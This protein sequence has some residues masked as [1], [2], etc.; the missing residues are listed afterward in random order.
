[1]QAGETV[2]TIAEWKA[3]FQALDQ[4]PW[5][6]PRPLAP[7]DATRFVGRTKEARDFVNR[8]KQHRLVVLSGESGVGK[9]SLLNARLVPELA[10]VG[11]TPLVCREWPSKT[12]SQSIDD[13]VRAQA[14]T[15]DLATSSGSLLEQLDSTFHGRAVVI[16][17]QLEEVIRYQPQLFSDLSQWVIEANH[18][19]RTRFVLSLR[20][21]YSHS[22]RSIEKAA[23]PFSFS[24]QIL[25]H[26]IDSAQVAEVISSESAGT[27]GRISKDAADI[28]L[29]HWENAG[30][31]SAR[32]WHGVGLLHLQATLYALHH[33]AG[34]GA[35]LIEAR[36][37]VALAASSE[38]GTEHFGR[39]LTV[40]DLGL[41][42]AIRVKL[43]HCRMACQEPGETGALDATLVA[44][45]E[46]LAYR[47]VPHLYSGGYK[48]E[49][50]AGDLAALTLSRELERLTGEGR[51]PQEAF[52]EA[53]CALKRRF[54]VV[55]GR[56]R[57]ALSAGEHSDLLTVSRHD[58][59]RECASLDA[60]LPQASTDYRT[61]GV[62]VEPWVE[63]PLELS[64]GPMLGMPP[65]H[66]LIEEMRRLLFAQHWLETAQLVRSSQPEPDR[67]ML[68]LIHDGFADA[69]EWLVRSNRTSPSEAL[70]LLT[71]ARGRTFD[72]S[73][74]EA[75]STPKEFSG[76]GDGLTWLNLRWNDCQVTASFSQLVFA[77]CDF[78]GT[79]FRRCR[80]E[81][82][83]FVNCLMD[84]VSFEECVV[85]GDVLPASI[86]QSKDTRMGV[87]A[88][89]VQVRPSQVLEL[90][91]YR[92]S[93]GASAPL[94]CFVYSRTS[95]VSA[96]PWQSAR[97]WD[98]I[99]WKPG[100]GGVAMFG[101]RLSSL[102]VRACLFEDGGALGL[103]FVAGAAL[104]IV[105]TDDCRI[106]VV[107]SAIRG[108]TVSRPIEGN[109]APDVNIRINDSILAN[110]W[111]GS[112]LRGS[113]TLVNSRVYQLYNLSRADEFE[114]RWDADTATAGVVNTPESP[115]EEH[116]RLALS[117]DFRKMDYRSEPAR[118]EL[119][120]SKR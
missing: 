50:D 96:V 104:D 43:A 2:R 72:W 7:E 86:D 94:D 21:E 47:M 15:D 11:F 101:G 62:D 112:G 84:N 91:T 115:M 8:V 97:D 19:H 31:R 67:W 106:D 69:L 53:F 35:R 74:P 93:H 13:Y 114:I 90:A 1:M 46:A 30:S 38:L 117:E 4:C 89:R 92:S 120:R 82:V 39:G 66:V 37:V 87:P 63:D 107:S 58:V 109:A 75:D 28:L 105:E 111:L 80:F 40:F 85:V 14:A 116:Q 110:T 3:L 102:M 119:S 42:E 36:H 56:R 54:Q 88:F 6:G 60:T 70:H 9:S 16:L 33:L 99:E 48:L 18:N 68:S 27:S 103:R 12:P 22:L 113:V 32:L 25:E 79:R 118:L 24:S 52:R 78:S 71:A 59:I 49:R 57:D 45:A 98:W 26:V 100:R 64:A 61:E 5:P 55:A 95:G 76:S 41:R 29:E 108:L 34:G 83:V 17:D 77:N 73:A 20:L 81:G 51:V 10:K 44:G 65:S 23:T